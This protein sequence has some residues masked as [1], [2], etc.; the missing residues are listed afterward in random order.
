MPGAADWT[1]SLVKAPPS[2][3][4]GT[5]GPAPIDIGP[6]YLY[7]DG[8][9]SINR[10]IDRNLLSFKTGDLSLT[11][12]NRDGF[13][14]ELFSD[15]KPTDRWVVTVQ[16]RGLAV[17]SGIVMGLGSI[18]YDRTHRVCQ[19][20][21][22]G[23]TRIL[24]D[25][26]AEPVSRTFGAITI[27]GA[28]AVSATVLPLSTTAGMLQG[29]MLHLLSTDQA[30]T[31]DVIIKTVDSA[32]Q[33]TLK[34]GTSNAYASPDV[35]TVST[36]YYRYKTIDFLIR[37]LFQAAGIGVAEITLSRSQFGRAAPSPISWNGLGVTKAL[38][39]GACERVV[40]GQKRIYAILD[41]LGSY[42]QPTGSPD[43]DWLQ[44]DATLR[45]WIDWSRYRNQV[46][47]APDVI[48]R[49]P[50]AV[51]VAGSEAF[52]LG[53]DNRSATKKIYRYN[54]A[55]LSIESNT[56]TDGTTWTGWVNVT[57][58]ALGD[59]G[60]TGCEFDP[61]RNLVYHT[62]GKSVQSLWT[63]GVYDVSGGG[64]GGQLSDA[65][66]NGPGYHGFRYIPEKDYVLALYGSWRTIGG[67]SPSFFFGSD[68]QIVALRGIS[69][70]WTRPL[71]KINHIG[72]S[73]AA[74]GP[75]DRIVSGSTALGNAFCSLHGARSIN[76]VLYFVA[77]VNGQLS[78]FWSADDF[79][80]V[81][82]KSIGGATTSVGSA[83]P[84]RAA[85]AYYVWSY[86]TKGQALASDKAYELG[87]P[88]YAGVIPYADHSGL[89]VAEALKNLAVLTNAV[90]WV[91]DDFEGHFVARDLLPALPP[92]EIGGSVLSRVETHLWD[93]SVQYVEVSG[94]SAAAQVSGNHAFAASGLSLSSPFMP[95]DAMAQAL[96][97]SY[98]AFLS[99][100][101]RFIE[102][103]NEDKDGRIFQPLDRV[104]LDGLRYLVYE[105]EHD[106]ANDQATLRLLEDV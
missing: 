36:P 105:S 69:V 84:G 81:T 33:V 39:S 103:S 54:P 7:R 43:A 16:R 92:V 19:V 79:K 29:D 94:G 83:H 106:P 40:A 31:E 78:L 15:L 77:F 42:Y 76:G 80:T 12:R 32:M 35:V 99:L 59:T 104:L 6:P 38:V 55:T 82:Y 8:F 88:F 50:D 23:P 49:A 3:Y 87:A 53:V 51:G 1:A 97:D 4:H 75:T 65:D 58:F 93:Q 52:A 95:N 91:D 30:K 68:C 22:Y 13:A 45:P 48:L 86:S 37:Q 5:P 71:P 57:S 73:S 66:A 14:D 24:E 74:A 61:V 17:A 28:V 10:A 18:K 63:S 21:G 56:T 90:F 100:Q 98:Y 60:D 26:S 41:T 34:A 9:G 44:E 46:D 89:S 64:A 102:L 2:T 25:S 72:G 62:R 47:G 96:A 27:T 101:R 11:L 85:D 70:L 67:S 20:I